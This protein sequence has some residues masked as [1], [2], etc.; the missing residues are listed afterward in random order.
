MTSLELHDKI[1]ELLGDLW[2]VDEPEI[3][4]VVDYILDNFEE[5]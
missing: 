2:T 3:Y 1:S 4:K 5:K